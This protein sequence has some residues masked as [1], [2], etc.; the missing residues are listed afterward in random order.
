[1]YHRRCQVLYEFSSFHSH[2]CPGVTYHS[3]ICR[4]KLRLREVKSLSQH[5]TASKTQVFVSFN[6]KDI[7]L[8][9]STIPPPKTLLLQRRR[10]ILVCPAETS[11]MSPSPIPVCGQKRIMPIEQLEQWRPPMLINQV[12]QGNS[13][14]SREGLCF[15][16]QHSVH[17]SHGR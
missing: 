14:Q 4:R 2:A 7:A 17:C 9:C 6:S 8:N 10:D 13:Q 15:K 11:W 12:I 3:H 16:A 5:Y 1:M